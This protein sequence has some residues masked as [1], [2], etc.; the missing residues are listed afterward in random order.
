MKDKKGKRLE[1]TLENLE[2]ECRMLR[3]I[4]DRLNK[5]NKYLERRVE[6]VERAGL[7]IKY[8]RALDNPTHEGA[9]LLY[10]IYHACLDKLRTMPNP[11]FKKK[12]V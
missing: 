7:P 9:A 6:E 12:S 3:E 2:A 4:N 5:K 11:V 1:Q 8:R 10:R